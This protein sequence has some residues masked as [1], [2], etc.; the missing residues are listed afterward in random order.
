MPA[1]S[2]TWDRRAPRRTAETIALSRAATTSL[3]CARS[4]SS[5]SARSLASSNDAVTCVLRGREEK[6]RAAAAPANL[7]MRANNGHESTIDRRGGAANMSDWRR[8]VTPSRHTQVGDGEN[9]APARRNGSRPSAARPN[10]API[11]P[12]PDEDHGGYH[13][14]R[15]ARFRRLGGRGHRAT[16]SGAATCSPTAHYAGPSRC[17]P[18][19]SPPI[20]RAQRRVRDV[21]GRGRPHSRPA[22]HPRSRRG[23]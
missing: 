23:P 10:P 16:S 9:Q 19:E 1:A 14:R 22:D 2:A 11:R 8:T 4:R 12:R 3:S 7:R 15:A 5:S 20:S 18:L 17:L 13:D 21:R 6:R